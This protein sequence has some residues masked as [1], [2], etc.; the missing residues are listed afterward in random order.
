MTTEFSDVW[1]ALFRLRDAITDAEN[2]LT[3][4]RSG[5]GGA[6][7]QEPTGV[8]TAPR[9]P[10]GSANHVAAPANP[11]ADVSRRTHPSTA[12]GGA[13]STAPV[14][15]RPLAFGEITFTQ[16][17]KEYRYAG[18]C[19]KC[20]QAAVVGY[21]PDLDQRHQCWECYQAGRKR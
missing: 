19:Y 21:I 16:R 13:F 12:A 7:G 11:P 8:G 20:G 2:K 1:A 9:L 17:G 6:S 3:D 18:Q 14:S 4:L 5:M 10:N 15:H